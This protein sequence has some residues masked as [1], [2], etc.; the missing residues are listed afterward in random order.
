MI[1]DERDVENAEV[2]RHLEEKG[3]YEKR[4][5]EKRRREGVRRKR[6]ETRK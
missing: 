5:R 2:P 3:G 4:E 6:M 1:Y